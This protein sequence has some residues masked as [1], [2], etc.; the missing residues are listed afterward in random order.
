MKNSLK[1]QLRS[2]LSSRSFNI[3]FIISVVFAVIPTV[4]YGI[5]FY[6]ADINSVPAAYSFFI[7]STYISEFNRI[8]YI[9][10]PLIVAVPFADSYYTDLKSKTIYAVLSKCSIKNYY[11]GKL[12]CVF[13]SGFIIIALP[14]LI[15]FLLNLAVFPTDSTVE[16]LYGFGQIQNQLFISAEDSDPI[17]FYKLFCTN[18]YLY[19]L[20]FLF[21]SAFFGGLLA[22]AVYQ[23][24][25]FWRASRIL[26]NCILFIIVNL[27]SLVSNYLPVNM[28][29]SSYIFAGNIWSSPS[30]A[31]FA[32]TISLCAAA[33]VLPAPFVMK[34]MNNIL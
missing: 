22:C 10:F 19:E 2:L 30:Y 6:G 13:F 9:I 3:V 33:A 8:Y 7:G 12:I 11:Y 21:T 14:M 34:R 28:N 20:A 1:F 29:L 32:L 26:L 17:L 23:L 27:L 16:F 4:F 5:T 15:N 24:S 31:G 25:F 18:Q